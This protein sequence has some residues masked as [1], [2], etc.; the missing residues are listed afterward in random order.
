M[1]HWQPAVDLSTEEV[2]DALAS[3]LR[4]RSH[5]EETLR[6]AAEENSGDYA[7]KDGVH[8]QSGDTGEWRDSRIQTNRL[9]ICMN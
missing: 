2:E 5:I 9:I 4:D 6:L 7:G 3:I 1:A 8:M